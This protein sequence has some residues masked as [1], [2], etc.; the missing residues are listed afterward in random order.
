MP[1][2]GSTRTCA[3]SAPATPGSLAALRLAAGWTVRRRARSP[4]PRRRPRLDRAARRRHAD[5]PRRRVAR[6]GAGPSLRPRRG[7]GRRHV[8][9]LRRRRQPAHERAAAATA[10]A[11]SIPAGL[12]WFAVACLGVAMQRIDA[13]ARAIPLDAPWTAPGAA[14]LDARTIASWID[15]RLNVPSRTARAML[16]MTMVDLF[17]S[18]PSEVSLLYVL[19]HLHSAGGLRNQTSI[20]GGVQQDRVVGGMQAIA[21]RIVARLGDAVRLGGA[22]A[23]DPPGRR[24][25]GGRRGPGDGPRA[26]ARDRGDPAGA[27]GP[28]PLRAAA[29]GRA[30]APAATAPRRLDAA[31]SRSSTTSRSG[32]PTA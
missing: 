22:G 7:D 3:S 19:F 9:D 12:G 10:T 16:R 24:R 30:R 25:R 20:E 14:A 26:S 17:T 18:D 31:R 5:R 28:H 13:M 32:A 2:N 23:R 15:S 4:R 27:R 21:D 1:W 8:S 6:P 11:G 29:A